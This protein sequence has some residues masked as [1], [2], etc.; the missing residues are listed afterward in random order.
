MFLLVSSLQNADLRNESIY[1]RL[2]ASSHRRR[3]TAKS[4]PA[5]EVCVEYDLGVAHRS[6]YVG[7]RRGRFSKCRRAIRVNRLIFNLAEGIS[8][9]P[10]RGYFSAFRAHLVNRLSFYPTLA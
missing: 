1:L 4:P 9:I 5:E 10:T 6:A 3:T 7:K 2:Q 8:I